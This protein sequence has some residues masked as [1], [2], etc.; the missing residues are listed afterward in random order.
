MHSSPGGYPA[1]GAPYA[2]P[3]GGGGGPSNFSPPVHFQ[4]FP[5]SPTNFAGPLP[6][7]VAP[8]WAASDAQQIGGGGP[9]GPYGG[10]GYMP[11]PPPLG[12]FVPSAEPPPLSARAPSSASEQASAPTTAGPAS[13]SF[14]WSQGIA[15]G[16]ASVGGWIPPPPPP[17]G[18]DPELY[19]QH[20]FMPPVP[21]GPQYGYSFP[22]QPDPNKFAPTAA[23]RVQPY[24]GPDEPA[25]Q[26]QQQ[27][28][29]PSSARL[30]T[31]ETRVERP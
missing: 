25:E 28:Q 30:A 14:Q 20:L 8:P 10:N 6:L 15:P 24:G 11:G 12:A 2:F 9:G 13:S 23:G 1:P 16:L 4:S 29:H 3:P 22:P 18:W 27:Q 17:P 31:T 5:G 21:G 7:S 19:H 26:Q